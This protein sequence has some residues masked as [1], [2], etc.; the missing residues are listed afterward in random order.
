MLT[1]DIEWMN[2]VLERTFHHGPTTTAWGRIKKAL[3]EAETQ[4]ASPTNTGSL[5][6]PTL[7]E[8]YRVM[9]DERPTLDK[10]TNTKAVKCVYDYI[11]G[12]LKA[13]A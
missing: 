6:L 13:G 7:E 11:V 9:N 4:S 5:Q 8:C 1:D 10:F 3:A 12:Q 2:M